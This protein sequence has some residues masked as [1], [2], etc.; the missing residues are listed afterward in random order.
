MLPLYPL[1]QCCLVLPCRGFAS[2]I[3]KKI[4]EVAAAGR[5]PHSTVRTVRSI[6]VRRP[7][8]SSCGSD[9]N[10]GSDGYVDI[11]VRLDGAMYKMV[12][13]LVGAAVA[14]ASAKLDA[15]TILEVL[16]SGAWAGGEHDRSRA[17][18]APARGLTL[19]RVYYE[20]DDLEG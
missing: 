4:A 15:S 9:S 12:R 14:I 10:C 3:D 5:P 18:P 6:T 8:D 2:K 17:L 20:G 1:S 16:D 7:I 19:E 13:H 11:D